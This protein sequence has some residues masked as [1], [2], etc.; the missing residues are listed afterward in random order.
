MHRHD[1]NPIARATHMLAMARRVRE[2]L[3]DP[4]VLMLSHV[5]RDRLQRVEAALDARE[6]L[7]A[8]LLG[9]IKVTIE[10]ID[11]EVE[12]GTMIETAT[13]DAWDDRGGEINVAHAVER[14]TPDAQ[15][16]AQMAARLRE[17]QE[18]I[19]ATLDALAAEEIVERARHSSRARSAANPA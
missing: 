19:L 2:A 12:R 7:G 8:P 10:R 3:P 18:A 14:L 13:Y 15:Y 9:D 16:L 4:R 6:L 5:D 11:A 17:L 1:D